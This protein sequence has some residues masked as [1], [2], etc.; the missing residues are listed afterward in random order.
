MVLALLCD[1]TCDNA[2]V[3][4]ALFASVSAAAVLVI[5]VV[6]M[7]RVHRD[8]EWAHGGD[9]LAADADVAVTTQ[10]PFEG[11]VVRLGAPPGTAVRAHSADQTVVV[12]VRWSAS[13]QAEGSYEL[14]TLDKRVT[15]PRPLAADGGWNFQGATG[16]QPGRR[17]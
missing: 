4:R 11:V 3:R 13:P 8:R 16:P 9:R 14:I 12:Q 7:L 10:D 17:L 15:P 1:E 6:V 2:R 5:A